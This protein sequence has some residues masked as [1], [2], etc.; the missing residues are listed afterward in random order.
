VTAGFPSVLDRL[1]DRYPSL[2]VDRVDEHEPGRRMTAVKN[3][4][5]NEEYFQ[6]HYPGTPLLPAVLTIEA[7]AQVA[8]LLVVERHPGHVALRGVNRAK[9]RRQVVPGDRL[10]LDVTLGDRR[11]P[12]VFVHGVASVDGQ[13][14]AEA[15]LLLATLVNAAD[16]DRSARVHPD[17]QIGAGTSVGPFAVIGPK[18]VLGR[19]CKVGASAIIDGNTRVGDGTEIFPFASIGLPPQ[20]LKYRGEDTRLTIGRGNIFREFVTVHRGTAGGGGETSIGDDNLFMA[21]AHV[22]HDCHIGHHTIFGNAATLGGHVRVEDYATISAYSGVHQFCRVGRHAFIGGY[23]VVTKDALPFAKSVGNRARVYGLNKIGLIR[24]GFTEERVGQLKR[25][26]RYLL[27]SK[28]NTTQALLHI[29]QDPTLASDE[30]AYLLE[31]IRTATRGVI[32]R[33]GRRSDDSLD[34]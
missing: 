30:V 3:V 10:R 9:F 32:L 16:I 23:S 34:D 7:L 20:D 19:D 26:Y 28:L 11:G 18:V 5:V 22:A 12:L 25:A 15:E 29:E 6:G 33:R 17:A 21:Y 27:Q 4:T 1:R 14:V 31:F 24:R 13:T 2:L 8:T